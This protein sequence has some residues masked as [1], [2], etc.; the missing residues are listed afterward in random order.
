MLKIETSSCKYGK[1]S[2]LADDLWVGKSL[3]H[4]GE[5]S[6]A[7]VELMK[8][9]IKPGNTVLDVGANFGALTL[10]MA[11]LVGGHGLV[12]AFEPQPQIYD[13]L[14]RN[15]KQNELENVVLY[16]CA[17]GSSCGDI[18]IPNLESTGSH[19]YSGVS[20]GS[21]DMTAKLMI[22]DSLLL[23]N[24]NFIKIDVEGFEREV[25]KGARETIKRCRPFLYVE[26]DR[27]ENSSR[28]IS[29]IVDLGYR[30]YWHRPMLFSK[31]N[32]RQNSHNL[33]PAILSINMICVP[34]ENSLVKL[35]GLEEVVNL[36][37]GLCWKAGLTHKEDYDRN[38][39]PQYV[40]SLSS[41]GVSWINLQWPPEP[42]PFQLE[43]HSDEIGD[44]LDAAYVLQTLDLVV[45]ID[46]AI[47][48]LAGALGIPCVVMLPYDNSWRWP[49]DKVI[50]PWYPTTTQYRQ[51]SPNDW[52]SVIEK[53]KIHINDAVSGRK[54]R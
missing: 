18:S 15:I 11:Q 14:Y 34:K 43:D 12:Y 1:M 20:I 24:V 35:E 47:A 32:F 27:P 8:Q 10:P 28:L 21:G 45:T 22:I 41:I 48:H 17:V 23:E 54:G 30:L 39:P 44:F 3:H 5:F 37:V 36:R 52:V 53:V 33:F 7:E 6:D 29:D 13:L 42:L 4:Y 50:S 51:D 25:I 38:I 19:N 31:V 9:L 49:N 46:T 26:N 16:N 40:A 2:Y